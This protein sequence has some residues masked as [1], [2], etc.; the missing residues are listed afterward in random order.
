MDQPGHFERSL[1]WSKVEAHQEVQWM[2]YQMESKYIIKII[3]H[4]F[5]NQN[6]I[7]NSSFPALLCLEFYS[8]NSHRQ[9]RRIEKIVYCLKCFVS[10]LP[11]SLSYP[12]RQPIR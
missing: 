5:S 7:L 6:K 9:R 4:Y 12:T 3:N 2:I 11:D 1:A 10:L 8:S